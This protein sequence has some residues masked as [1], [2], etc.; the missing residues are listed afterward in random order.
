MPSMP[1]A[2]LQTGPAVRWNGRDGGHGNGDVALRRARA[3][4]NS[5]AVHHLCYLRNDNRKR[6]L[7]SL[8]RKSG[9][10][11][12]PNLNGAGNNVVHG[13]L[14]YTRWPV[15]FHTTSASTLTT[16]GRLR[17]RRSRGRRNGLGCRGAGSGDLACTKKHKTG[18]LLTFH[19]SFLGRESAV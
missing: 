10:R 7:H 5:H 18:V 3:L 15:A 12:G 1:S 11:R 9:K 4:L 17:Y 8:M 2:I 14:G 6:K 13:T 16:H 19:R